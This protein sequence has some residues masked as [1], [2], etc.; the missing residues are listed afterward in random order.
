MEDDCIMWHE[1]SAE[2]IKKRARHGDS[3]GYTDTQMSFADAVL[4][5]Y[6]SS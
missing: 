6:R 5:Q 1:F 4:I 3:P 2:Q